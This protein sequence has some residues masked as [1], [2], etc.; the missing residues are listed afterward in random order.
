MLTVTGEHSETALPQRDFPV[1]LKKKSKTVEYIR[2][3]GASAE[4]RLT[5]TL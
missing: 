1:T 2:G 3:D 5:D 4:E